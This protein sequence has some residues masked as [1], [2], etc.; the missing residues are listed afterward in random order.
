MSIYKKLARIHINKST[1]EK[2]YEVLQSNTYKSSLYKTEDLGEGMAV[3]IRASGA[4][5]S[6]DL[7]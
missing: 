4:G 2:L 1:E 6:R 7:C 5:I 3:C